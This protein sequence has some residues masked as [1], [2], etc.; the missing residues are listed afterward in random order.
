M[1]I[2][3]SWD[4]GFI[5]NPKQTIEVPDEELDDLSHE[6][7]D[8]LIEEYVREAFQNAVSYS[9]RRKDDK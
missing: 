4:D 9:W 3:W 2:E 5:G 7:Q 1:K 6:E 8:D